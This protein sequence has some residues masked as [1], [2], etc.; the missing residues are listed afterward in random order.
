M[1]KDAVG[2]KWQLG[3]I[4]VDYNLPE[5]F[6]LEYTGSDN[7]KHRPVMIH[8]A[9]F[10][11]LERFIAVLIEHCGGNFPLWLTPDQF[12]ILPLSEKYNGYAQKVLDALTAM[13]LRGFLDDRNETIGKKIRDNEVKKVPFMLIVGEKEEAEQKVALRA[14]GKGDVGEFSVDDFVKYVNQ[15]IEN[16]FNQ[17]LNS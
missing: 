13:D 4:Q 5:R 8:R 17:K 10:G 7:Q 2:R 12:A 9:P 3:T 14:R 15:I 6:E 11:S 16:D 1:V